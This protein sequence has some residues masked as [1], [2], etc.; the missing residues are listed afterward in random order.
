[1]WFPKSTLSMQPFWNKFYKLRT[2]S[3]LALNPRSR[4]NLWLS[5]LRNRIFDSPYLAVFSGRPCPSIQSAINDTRCTPF[6]RGIENEKK[7]VYGT[8]DRKGERR[9][10]KIIFH[11]C[12]HSGSFFAEKFSG[13]ILC[14]SRFLFPLLVARPTLSDGR[15]I[16]CVK[17]NG[18]KGKRSIGSKKAFPWY[19]F[20]D[21][22]KATVTGQRHFNVMS[23]FRRKK[24]F[25]WYDHLRRQ[26]IRECYYLRYRIDISIWNQSCICR[27][28]VLMWWTVKFYKNLKYWNI[29]I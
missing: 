18:T 28:N 4:D 23:N 1:M 20:R 26:V 2:Y 5:Q 15:K 10:G 3:S 21:E 9:E 19:L 12:I 27:S 8:E 6:R 24:S 22:G 13:L 29:A 11:T 7:D 14:H 16:K 25:F 17:F